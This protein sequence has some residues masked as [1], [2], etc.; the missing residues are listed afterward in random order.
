MT[1]GAAREVGEIFN[2]ANEEGVGPTEPVAAGGELD[3]L[4]LGEVIDNAL[5]EDTTDLLLLARRLGVVLS[6]VSTFGHEPRDFPGQGEPIPAGKRTSYKD[7]KNY[8]TNLCR[9]AVIQDEHRPEI[10]RM[11]D[12][13]NSN[14]ERYAEVERRTTV[15]WF[16]IGALHYRE[17]NLNF[18]GH[19]HNGDNLLMTTVHVPADRP[20]Q[21]PGRKLV[22]HY[23]KFGR[24]APS[25]LC[26]K[27]RN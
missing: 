1:R 3:P 2:L 23:A 18:L 8:Y 6:A 16:V 7:M 12:I 11:V 10:I 21:R 19:L 5:S 15:P 27:S 26:R 9:S 4:T 22:R 13:I 25:T 20:T 14:K 17:A 24:I